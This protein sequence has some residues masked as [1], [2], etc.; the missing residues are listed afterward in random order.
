MSKMKEELR[1]QLLTKNYTAMERTLQE[2]EKLLYPK[3][4][5]FEYRQSDVS[6]QGQL[7]SYSCR[8][9]FADD[10]RGERPTHRSTVRTSRS[11][12]KDLYTRGQHSYEVRAPVRAT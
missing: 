10:L 2:L 8:V 4:A 3:V 11:G 6:K 1:N 5:V 7:N 9:D 12:P